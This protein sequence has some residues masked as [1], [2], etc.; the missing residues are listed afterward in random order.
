MIKFI[1]LIVI[2]IPLLA[3]ILH[4]KKKRYAFLRDLIGGGTPESQKEI[5]EIKREYEKF[6]SQEL[7]KLLNSKQLSPKETLIANQI[8]KERG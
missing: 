3:L 7:L 5:L 6:P 4:S 1:L 2:I 8:L